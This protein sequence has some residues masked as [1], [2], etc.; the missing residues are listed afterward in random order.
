MLMLRQPSQTDW[1]RIGR[2]ADESVR[3]LSGVPQQVEWLHR[4][5]AFKGQRAQHVAWN[6]GR[7]VGYGALERQD[8]ALDGDYRLFLVVPWSSK[9]SIP[10]A[11]A[12][13]GRL[14]SDAARF[15]ARRVWLREYAHDAPFIAYLLSRGFELTNEY[16]H[17]G[18]KLA[19]LTSTRFGECAG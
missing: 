13:L 9:E 7:L 17:G 4:R 16:E 14:R 18:E 5:L 6:G 8:G 15:Y 3:H 1:S 10:I 19:L 11:D 12:L 2:V